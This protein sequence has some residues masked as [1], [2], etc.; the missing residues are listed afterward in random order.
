MP[1][2]ASNVDS[3]VQST[4][5]LLDNTVGNAESIAKLSDKLTLVYDMLV[6][7]NG[8]LYRINQYIDYIVAFAVV[9]LLCILYYRYL[10]YFTR[11]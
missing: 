9:I 4:E 5:Q 10:E 3:V 7:I 2:L 8:F 1:I 11:F 6:S